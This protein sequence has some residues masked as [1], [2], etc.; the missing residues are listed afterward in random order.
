MRSG[1]TRSSRRTVAP[2]PRHHR[3][4]AADDRPGTL[5]HFL[6]RRGKLGAR[7]QSKRRWLVG[8]Q[9]PEHLRTAGR[10]PQRDHR[11][12]RVAGDVRRGQTEPLDQRSE[13]VG[14]PKHAPFSRRPLT[15]AVAAPVVDKH[16][17]G[18]RQR[19]DHRIPIVM[20]TPRAVHKHQRLARAAQL[21]IELH[22]VDAREG[23]LHPFGSTRP[24][25]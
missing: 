17:K 1:R 6:Q 9:A 11:T 4:R 22:T 21:V 25:P 19:T 15:R 7:E 16:A 5:L 8:D 14:V 10:C 20:I 24:G 13:I 23:H 18:P 3:V 2:R 12:E